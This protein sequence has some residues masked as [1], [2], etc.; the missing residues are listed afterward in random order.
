M[1]FKYPLTRWNLEIS[2]TFLFYFS[3]LASLQL[4][5]PSHNSQA[6]LLYLF[7]AATSG[8]SLSIL[9]FLFNLFVSLFLLNLNPQMLWF[10]QWVS[11]NF[12][13]GLFGFHLICLCILFHSI[14]NNLFWVRL[15]FLFVFSF[16]GLSC[17]LCV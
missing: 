3:R 15:Y 9:I 6:L 8:L 11:F 4:S 14:F 2:R 16:V 12:F 10:F 7:L 13:M 1:Y 5:L 17:K